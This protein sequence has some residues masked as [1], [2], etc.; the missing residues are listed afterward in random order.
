MTETYFGG[1]PGFSFKRL[2][3]QSKPDQIIRLLDT[4]IVSLLRSINPT[5]LTSTNYL[6]PIC[7]KLI[8]LKDTLK[9][10]ENRAYILCLLPR[11]KAK[12]L[13]ER[14]SQPLNADPYDQLIKIDFTS[15][16]ALFDNLLSFFGIQEEERAPILTGEEIELCKAEYGL[17]PHQ[18]DVV[19][20]LEKVLEEHPRKALL[21]MPTGAGKTRTAMNIV[22]R[23]LVKDE[24]TL[25][26]W[27]AQSAELLEQSVEEFKRAWSYLGNRDVKIYR[28]WG[29]YTPDLVNVQTGILIAGF[30]KI[31]ALYKRDAN[32]LMRLGD[33]I[34]LTIVDEAHQAIAPTF[35]SIID[36]L[37]TKQ[38]TSKLLGLS[39]TPGR[40]WNNIAADAELANYFGTHKVTLKIAGYSD[41]VT[42]LID[43][44]YLARPAFRLINSNLTQV[45]ISNERY[46]VPMFTDYTFETLEMLGLSTERNQQILDEARG[47]LD[48]HQRIILFASSVSH[49]KLMAAILSTEG[50]DAE[51]ITSDTSSGSRERIIRKFRSDEATPK[52]L[53]NYGVLT[54]GF[55]APKTSAVLIARPTL[56]LVLY[57]Q[58]VGRA[59][60]G[61]RQGGNSTA[62]VVTVVDPN[63]PGFGDIARAFLNWEDVWS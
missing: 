38:P 41:P 13:L 36:S 57:S 54:A 16:K 21:H 20:R 55:D 24:N 9:N 51:A 15:Q 7:L 3:L 49:A 45:K 26:C 59:I 4:N 11:E 50:H 8:D 53:C 14:I 6:A 43:E 40:T 47:L 33:R 63:L 46:S 31:Y 27:L 58:M 2:I 61:P 22:A 48:R 30:T 1:S 52:I 62:E 5:L 29:R 32:M 18:R 44:G 39:A 19:H 35:R 23:H 42:Y 37:H 28:Y 56:S 34:S 60:R 17:F 12:E 10:H 25:V